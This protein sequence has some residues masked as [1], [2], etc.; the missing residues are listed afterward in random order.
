MMKKNMLIRKRHF[1]SM[2]MLCVALGISG[3]GSQLTVENYTHEAGEELPE[4]AAAYVDFKNEGQKEAATVD[5]SKVDPKKVGSYEAAIVLDEKEYPFTVDVVDTTEPQGTLVQHF[6]ITA[7][8]IKADDYSNDCTDA[9][10][11]VQGIRNVEYLYT[12]EEV[13]KLFQEVVGEQK[14]SE[15]DF[16]LD[17]IFQTNWKNQSEHLWSESGVSMEGLEQVIVPEADGV[18]SMELVAVDEY[19]NA[20]IAKVYAMLDKTAPEFIEAK[21]VEISGED[22]MQHKETLCE[23]ITVSD[24]M[25]GDMFTAISVM[26]MSVV[27]YSP[28][29]MK[30]TYEVNDFA[31]NTASVERNVTVKSDELTLVKAG[32]TVPA[33]S[34]NQGVGSVYGPKLTQAEL[35]EVAG[36]VQ[37]FLANYI[38]EGM[39]D[40]QKVRAAN[41]FL[42]NTVSY[43]D[44]WAYNGAN[45]A[46]GALI[47]HEAQCSGFARAMKALCDGMGVGCY[48]VHSSTTSHQWNEVC[49]DGNWY[50]IDVT[51]NAT[52]GNGSAFLIS[53]ANFVNFWNGQ[54]YA[55]DWN[56]SSV[57]ACPNNY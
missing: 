11:F 35:D 48:Y 51:A 36:A 15:M 55:E 27:D 4:E 39:T 3:C 5:L 41:D 40:Y 38:T 50:I 22:F 43:A 25:V 34:S 52:A 20:G 28:V 44:S 47:Y 53:E 1:V 24:N 19:G 16:N 57:P 26:D 54:G 2:A 7:D 18:Y 42:C 49:V 13:S 17:E 8:D 6:L 21:D 14:I 23:G 46:W 10:E 45:T 12:A 29:K 32:E 33:A 37:S 30:V 9:S 56:R 31:G